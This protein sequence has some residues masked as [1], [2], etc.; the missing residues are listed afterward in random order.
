MSGTS[1]SLY[2]PPQEGAVSGDVQEAGFR[3][4]LIATTA[5]IAGLGDVGRAAGRMIDLL[6][7]RSMAPRPGYGQAIET[8]SVPST[9]PKRSGE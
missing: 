2:R 8:L 4:R 1:A 9:E 5:D 6:S 3:A 7:R